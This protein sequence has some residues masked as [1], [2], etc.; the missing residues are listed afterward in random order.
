MKSRLAEG[1][2]DCVYAD[3]LQSFQSTTDEIKSL[4]SKV[5]IILGFFGV[6]LSILIANIVTK[7]YSIN[8]LIPLV[9][10]IT[11]NQVYQENISYQLLITPLKD[12]VFDGILLP[13]LI[14]LL[15][16]IA[17]NYFVLFIN[18]HHI[19][20][21]VFPTKEQ[22]EECDNIVSNVLR[23]N[24]LLSHLK[25]AVDNIDC[26]YKFYMRY[27][28]EFNHSV[29]MYF[30]MCIVVIFLYI[31]IHTLNISAFEDWQDYSLLFFSL[32]FSGGYLLL[33]CHMFNTILSHSGQKRIRKMIVENQDWIYSK[34]IIFS[35]LIPLIIFVYIGLL[36][37][38][39]I[40]LYNSMPFWI[41]VLVTI[42]L[43]ILLFITI[44]LLYYKFYKPV[45]D[46]LKQTTPKG[47]QR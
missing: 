16:M 26:D 46:L 40:F 13:F 31:I 27:L 47:M 9:S 24:K 8:N 30:L 39:I 44:G 18:I 42:V 28:S 5:S 32:G 20:N 33:Q 3:Y 23:K 2:E 7:S 37:V 36:Y 11:G 29:L 4:R 38:L 25:I 12:G 10:Q 41:G 21:M 35:G 15:I 17:V 22:L 43:S 6:A 34:I 1:H 45:H 14:F 19:P